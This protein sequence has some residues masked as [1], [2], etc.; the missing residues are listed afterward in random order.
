MKTGIRQSSGYNNLLQPPLQLLPA[1]DLLIQILQLLKFKNV[2]MKYN[3]TLRIITCLAVF[4]LLLSGQSCMNY[5]KISKTPKN[6]ATPDNIVQANPQR[7]FILRSGSN[8]YY[9]NNIVLSSDRKSLTCT[10]ENLPPEHQLHLRSGRAG[11]MR[12]K[13]YKPE[14]VVLNEVHLYIQQD[15]T[16]GAGNSYT[17]FLDKVQKIEVLEKDKGRTTTSYILGGLGYTVGALVVATVIIIA[18]KSSCPFVSAYTGNDISLQGEI[19]GGAI[20]PQLARHDYIQLKMAPASN[21]NLQ[22][23]ISN[24]LK[25]RQYTDLAELMVVTH[26][27]DVRMLVDEYGKLYSVSNPITPVAANADNKDV[28]SL[29]KQQ[30]D[31]QLYA[32]DDTLAAKGSNQ[33]QLTFNK[34]A[35]VKKAKLILRLKNSYWMDYVYGKMTEGFGNYYNTFIQQQHNK[36]VEDLKRWIKDQ[37]IPLHVSIYTFAGWQ[38]A[39]DITTF[40]P[41]AT[42]ETVIPLD[43]TAVNEKSIKVQLSCGFMFWEVDYAA[44]D[45]S[46]DAQFN[47]TQLS[48]LKATDETGT[49]VTQLLTT[50]DGNYLEQPVPGNAVNIEYAFAPEKDKNKTQTFILHAKG[51][52]EHVRDYKSLPNVTFL[53]QFKKADALSLYSMKLYKDVMT[54]DAQSLVAK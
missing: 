52:Y 26:N 21:G 54:G 48:P 4:I 51:Y 42:R 28:L 19:Y 23:Q 3:K 25:E 20:Y 33:L 10:L 32:F 53:E 14:A 11:H 40:G 1:I 34:P 35:D 31:N 16:T 45:F 15:N 24:E 38:K 46:N 39:A 30:N 6:T 18:T 29:V 27:R 43:L 22:L 50:A 9:M 13:K 37:E 7:Y 5:Y 47:V 2:F 36:P 8:A 41:L 17:L 12:Y 49:E 44:I